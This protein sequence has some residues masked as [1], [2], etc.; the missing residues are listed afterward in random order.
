M[1]NL[2][3]FSKR[4]LTISISLSVVLLSAAVFMFSIKTA[5]AS[6]KLPFPTPN[7][8]VASENYCPLGIYNGYVYYFW[9]SGEQVD[10]SKIKLE[11]ATDYSQNYVK[12]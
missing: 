3:T 1:K 6:S 5:T 7:P 10:F 8:T 9:V 2:D 11:I 12:K 4:F